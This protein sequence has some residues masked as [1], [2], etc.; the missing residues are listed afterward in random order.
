MGLALLI[1]APAGRSSAGG[2]AA[3]AF[4]PPSVSVQVGHTVAV[5]I[6]A[7]GVDPE[8][9]LAGYDLILSFNPAVVRLDRLDD[10]GFVPGG[11]NIVICVTGQIDNAAGTVNANCTAIPVFGQPG[12]SSDEPVALLHASFTALAAGSSPLR[13][14][15][16]LTAPDGAVIPA[17]FEEGIV[18]VSGG[19][20]SANLEAAPSAV[21]PGAPL[22]PAAGSGGGQR[23]FPVRIAILA[24][25]AVIAGF[26]GWLIVWRRLAS[27]PPC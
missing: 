15:G 10:S 18:Q 27:R 26:V 14:S 3:V 8:P 25:G 6:T 20:Q 5:D 19:D 12:V 9:G 23:T 13:L 11:E 4:A 22:P 17:T 21:P 16:S 2:T 1:G 24:G 7:A